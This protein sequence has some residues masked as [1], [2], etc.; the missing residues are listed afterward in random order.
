[1]NKLIKHLTGIFFL[2]TS[3]QLFAQPELQ[4]WG[5]LAGIR[6]EGQLMEFETNISVVKNNWSVV[7]ATGKE[8]QRPK[9]ERKENT[10][11]V[12]T[13]IDSIYLTESVTD[14]GKN[15]AKIKVQ[16]LAKADQV[17]EGIYVKLIIPDAY[18]PMGTIMYDDFEGISLT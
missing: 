18:Y 5:N 6:I 2:F 8:R 9:F 10:Q 17:L 16:A 13:R 7:S 11:I 14:A 3:T 12:T 15:T 1:M 4:P